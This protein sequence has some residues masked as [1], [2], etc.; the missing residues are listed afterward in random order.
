MIGR[1]AAENFR[2]GMIAHWRAWTPWVR[3]ERQDEELNQVRS[4]D[5]M[6]LVGISLEAKERPGWAAALR[7]DDARRAVKYATLEL[8]G[9]PVW[10]ADIALAKPKDVR[11]VL[12]HEVLA[13]LKR[14]ADKL[15]FGLLYDIA[16]A[17]KEIAELM[18]ATVLEKIESKPD[19]P[20]EALA[21]A[22][23]VV[24][25]GKELQR[26]RLKTLA[27]DRFD[28]CSMPAA[29]YIGC[30]DARRAKLYIGAVFTIDGEAA[31][32]AVFTKL[33]KL[34]P[35][36]QAA[37][38]R[39]I[40]P[41]IF[42]RQLLDEEPAASDLP[43]GSL[44]QL[45]RLAYHTIRPE[46]DNV[47]PSGEVYSHDDRDDAEQARSAAFSRL[48]NT[49]GRA[50]F[51]SI[52]RLVDQPD[53]PISKGRLY[54]LARQRAETDWSVAHGNLERQLRLSALLKPNHKL[55][56]ICSLFACSG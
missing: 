10:L 18:A 6:G 42:G 43:L 5:S 47:H 11:A 41:R 49:P 45:V 14:P 2:L 52:L 3:S 40:L 1:E 44:E 20:V 25:R 31:T 4:L 16:R 8:N 55:R 29:L 24:L 12:S 30:S 27:L 17:D 54:E 50:T 7:S 35:V 26:G 51:N 46:D 19:L 28:G 21:P 56:M 23:D 53:F 34:D 38:V 9:F 33:A 48:V 39:Q 13:E 37:L 36:G 32:A 15:A 22:L